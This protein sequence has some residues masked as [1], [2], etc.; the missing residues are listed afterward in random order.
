MLD[1]ASPQELPGLDHGAVILI[2]EVNGH[3]PQGVLVAVTD[4]VKPGIKI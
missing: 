1:D 3:G 2:L 4:L